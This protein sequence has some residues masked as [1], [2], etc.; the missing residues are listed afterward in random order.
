MY[1]LNIMEEK[2]RGRMRAEALSMESELIHKSNLA[3]NFIFT[4]PMINIDHNRVITLI[5]WF[6]L[7]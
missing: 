1:T 3:Q 7:A 6:I 5:P 2:K 4:K